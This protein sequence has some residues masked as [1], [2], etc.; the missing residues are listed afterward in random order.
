FQR[1]F[2]PHPRHKSELGSV[3]RFA[4][5]HRRCRFTSS[6][7][8]PVPATY[9][10]PVTG[11]GATTMA[12]TGCPAPGLKLQ[13]PAIYGPPA[14]GVGMTAPTSGMPATGDR[15]SA[16]TVALTMASVTAATDSTAAS[17]AAGLSSTTP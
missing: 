4:S 5:A 9:G 12:T 1:F 10:L 8:A 13:N 7:F 14:T 6:L 3:F 17:G 16:S 2:R 15:I 11:L